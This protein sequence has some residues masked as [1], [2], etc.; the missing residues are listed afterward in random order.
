MT[1]EK[2]GIDFM[3]KILI[4]SYKGGTGKTTVAVNLA[5]ILSQ[6]TKV[7]LIEN[8][9][10]MPS[11]V[12]IFKHEPNAFF[13]DFCTGSATFSEIIQSNLK[14]SLD[15]IF[16]DTQFNPSAEIMGSNQAWFLKLLEKMM[17]NLKACEEIYEYVIFDTPPGWQLIL[18]NLIALANV[19]IL[20]LRPNSYEVMGT[21]RLIEILYK[22]AKP[23][24]NFDVN[25]LFNQV[26]EV[27][28]IKDL[29]GWAEEL[30][31]EGIS[32]LGHISCSCQ[33]AYEM[34][35]ETTIFPLE[36]EFSQSLQQVISNLKI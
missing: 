3:K 36:H 28:M 20:L 33:T 30:Q 13:N 35:H 17:E 23:S 5:S 4:H 18:V 31:I 29:E 27:D 26:P 8:D 6:N 19:A 22:R 9:F 11:F 34:A 2:L 7:L 24:M 14:P 21:K 12:N 15:I 16:A 25:L 32:Y 1:N 10:S